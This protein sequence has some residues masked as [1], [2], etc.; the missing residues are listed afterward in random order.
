LKRLDRY[1]FKEMW[2]PFLAGTFVVALMFQ[3][4]SYMMIAKQYNLESIPILA[5][6]QWLVYTL[7]SQ[8]KLTLPTG[9]ALAAALSIG[10]M[11]RES[12]VTAIRTAGAPVA[13]LMRPVILFGLIAGVLNFYMVDRI[14]PVYNKKATELFEKNALIAMATSNNL[15]ENSLI[16]LDKYAASLGTIKRQKNDVLAISDIMLIER[17]RSGLR[18]I[19]TA[20][21]GTYDAGLWSF[22]NGFSYQVNGIEITSFSGDSLTINQTVDINALFAAGTGGLQSDYMNW[23]TKDLRLA[24]STAAKTKINARPFEVE[25]YSRYA[26]GVACAI[27]AFTSAVFAVAFSRSGG[28][29]GLLVSFGVVVLYYNAYVISVEI[30]GKQENIPAWFAAW[31]PNIVFGL[32]GLIWLRRVE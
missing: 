17:E 3:A 31:L 13:R 4:N 29:A 18:T 2:I 25:L 8:L 24:I 9:M 22:P 10:R 30:L 26:A 11:A 16:Q 28:F 5:R 32:V 15:K 1:V 6:I 21:K 27:F 23:P 19:F 7:P 12:E 20:P 14:I